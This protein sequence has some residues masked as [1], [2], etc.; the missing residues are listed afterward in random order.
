[1][2]YTVKLEQKA[3]SKDSI[4]NSISPQTTSAPQPI[5][6]SKS[7]SKRIPSSKGSNG[8]NG[9][10]DNKQHQRKRSKHVRFS[11]IGSHTRSN[12][13]SSGRQRIAIPELDANPIP[14]PVPKKMH[15]RIILNDIAEGKRDKNY[16]IRI[17]SASLN[18]VEFATF[19]E[20]A[21][22]HHQQENSDALSEE[23]EEYEESECSS[24]SSASSETSSTE[25]SS[26]VYSSDHEF[27]DTEDDLE[28]CQILHLP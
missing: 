3:H 9:S 11:G 26:T 17:T 24:T 28:R 5:L 2:K 18:E 20:N 27:D 8:S 14:V 25:S 19:A 23:D 1:M 16:I 7:K 10:D 13:I 4:L 22:H 12:A 6:P 15:Q 21:V